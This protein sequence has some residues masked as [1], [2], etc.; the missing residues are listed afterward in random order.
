MHPFM[1][2]V[3]RYFGF[4]ENFLRWVALLYRDTGSQIFDVVITDT[5][6]VF[7]SLQL[8][9]HTL[10]YIPVLTIWEATPTS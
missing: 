2:A 6:N 4:D 1:L 10:C 3:M 9:I 5:S 8:V 7:L